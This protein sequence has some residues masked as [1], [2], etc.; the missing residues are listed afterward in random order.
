[1]KIKIAAALLFCLLA[2]LCLPGWSLAEGAAAGTDG[3]YIVGDK[4]DGN[5]YQ[6]APGDV[7]GASLIVG[8]NAL[9]INYSLTVGA[10]GKIFFPQ[11]GEFSLA[12]KTLTEAKQLI[13]ARIKEK[14]RE[15]Y[16]FSLR[17]DSPRKVQLYLS[18][19]DDKPLYIGEKKFVSIY[20]EVVKSGRFEYVPNKKF[21]DYISYAGGPTP[22]AN[23]AWASVSRKNQKINI[24]GSDVIFNG[25]ASDDIEIEPGD[26]INVPS[27][28]FYF[29]DF[30]SFST[31]L[32]SFVAL[33]NVVH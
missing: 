32:L 23:L 27:Q 2:N 7:L 31:M 10:D 12:G 22:R 26:V 1:M 11:V 17:L 9:A 30:G 18:G 33:Y 13:D 20:G 5:I 16:Y 6:L 4:I 3:N 29:S 19:A 28:F 8:N 25:N 15:A 24:N 21:S 14:Y